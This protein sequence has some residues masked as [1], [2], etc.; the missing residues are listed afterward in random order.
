MRQSRYK[1]TIVIRAWL[2]EAATGHDPLP[3]FIQFGGI[4]LSSE[5][6]RLDESDP[7]ACARLLDTCVS[8][9]ILHHMRMHA[10]MHVR[11]RAGVRAHVRS[12][13]CTHARKR[14]CRGACVH[15][16]MHGEMHVSTH[17]ALPR[18]LFIACCLL[19]DALPS[20]APH[21][22]QRK[23]ILGASGFC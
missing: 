7:S 9:T 1:V 18:L 20:L 5:L 10:C 14:A 16:E 11:T 15:A 19:G 12:C 17:T 23:Y 8:H 4:I 21:L 6:R 22:L 13:A 3:L 2:I